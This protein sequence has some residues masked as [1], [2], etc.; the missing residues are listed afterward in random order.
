MAQASRF[1]VFQQAC[2]MSGIYAHRSGQTLPHE[3][4]LGRAVVP[5][6]R[7]GHVLCRATSVLRHSKPFASLTAPAPCL[8]QATSRR[9]SRPSRHACGACSGTWTA[10][11]TSGLPRRC[12]A[13][14]HGA[15]RTSQ[16]RSASSV[17]TW[18]QVARLYSSLPDKDLDYGNVCLTNHMSD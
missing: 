11:R 16:V 15:F 7:G 8:T 3:P 13:M 12:C 6:Q 5:G 10:W 17:K 9:G 1:R 4:A 2:H 14:P 18:R